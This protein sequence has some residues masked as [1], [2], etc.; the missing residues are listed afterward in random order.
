MENS[1]GR[2]VDATL[3]PSGALS[4][5]LPQESLCSAKGSCITGW[6]ALVG[7][8]RAQLS[9]SPRGKGKTWAAASAVHPA[10]GC[11]PLFQL[12]HG[13]V[14]TTCLSLCSVSASQHGS[15]G[16]GGTEG[17]ELSRGVEQT[18]QNKERQLLL[19][20]GHFCAAA[21]SRGS[22]GAHRGRSSLHWPETHVCSLGHGP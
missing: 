4:S 9:H 2:S 21:A 15:P 22:K 7:F 16:R 8:H 13:G 17:W 3:A 6:K 14:S 10:R 18:L 11:L 19:K 20:V 12:V 5:P 1:H